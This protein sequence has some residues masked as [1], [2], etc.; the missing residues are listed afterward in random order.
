L[1][2]L[3]SDPDSDVRDWA[4]FGLGVQGDADSPEI[5]DALVRCLGDPGEDVREEAAVSLGKR[6]DP[7]VLPALLT[8]L[9]QPKLRIRVAEAAAALLGLESDPPE[10]TAADYQAA[11]A[12]KFTGN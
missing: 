1:L 8:M 12:L 5:R 7:R 3:T 4:V 10:W 6:R 9:D 2:K 11:L